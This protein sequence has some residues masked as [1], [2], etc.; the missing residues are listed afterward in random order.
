MRRLW[1]EIGHILLDALYPRRCPLCEQ[2]L[3]DRAALACPACAGKLPFLREPLCK[4]CGRPLA[5]PEEEYC[6][7][8]RQVKHAYREGRAVFLYEKRVR[9]ALMR[10]KF[11]NRREYADFFAWAMASGARA[12]LQRI[13]PDEI[14]PVPMHRRKIRERGFDQ[15]ALL[16]RR[17]SGRT[18]IPVR[19]DLLVRSRYTKPQKGLDRTERRSNLSGAFALREGTKPGERILILDDIYTTGSTIDEVSRVLLAGGAK[20]VYFLTL[21]IG[22]GKETV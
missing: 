3:T 10:M 13:H 14:V 2:I 5:A 19:E 8:C 20:E 17:L 6:A 22:K 15:C 16:A 9:V 12:Y 18:G 7:E 11:Q 1:R 4:C 21:C